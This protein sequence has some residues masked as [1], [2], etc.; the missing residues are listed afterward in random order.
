MNCA[1]DLDYELCAVDGE[2]RD[3][4]TDGI[5][6]FDWKAVGPQLAQRSPRSVFRRIRCLA[7]TSGTSGGSRVLTWKISAQRLQAGASISA[8]HPPFSLGRRAEDEGARRLITR[9]ALQ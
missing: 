5:L 8:R 4:R 9:S 7:Q 3:V 1:V 2:I 6:A